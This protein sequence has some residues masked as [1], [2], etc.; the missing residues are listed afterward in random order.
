L[1]EKRG[2]EKKSPEKLSEKIHDGD[3]DHRKKD[4]VELDF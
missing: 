4:P 1:Q 3:K 2:Q